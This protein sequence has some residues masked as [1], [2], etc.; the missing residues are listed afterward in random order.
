M[1]KS[2]VIAGICHELSKLD[3]DAKIIIFAPSKEILEQNAEKL[4]LYGFDDIKV[5]SASCGRKEVGQYTMAT[6]GSVKNHPELFKGT[7]YA[8]IDEMQDVKIDAGGMYLKFFEQVGITRY[9]GLTATPYKQRQ[10]YCKQGKFLEYTTSVSLVNRFPPIK[11]KYNP[12]FAWGKILYKIEMKDLQDMGYLCPIKYYTEMPQATLRLNSTGGDYAKADIEEFGIQSWNR[13]LTVVTRLVRAKNPKRVL[14]FAPSVKASQSVSQALIERGISADH[15]DGKTPKKERDE[16][17]ARF[18]SGETQVMCNCQCLTAGFD[19]PALDT[20]VYAMPTLSP[21]RWIQACYTDDM[22]I[23]TPSG[24]VP[25]QSVKKGDNVYAFDIETSRIE[26]VPVLETINRPLGVG[27][28]VYK[29]KTVCGGIDVSMTSTHDLVLKHHDGRKWKKEELS[30]ALRRKYSYRVPVAGYQEVDNPCELTKNECMFIGWWLSDGSYDKSNQRYVITQSMTNALYVDEIRTILTSLNIGFSESIVKHTGCLSKYNDNV[31]FRFSKKTT[32][33]NKIGVEKW[34]SW[35]NKEGTPELERLSREQL[36][37]VL[38]GY[39]HGNGINKGQRD[40]TARTKAATFG[41]NKVLAEK[42]Q[43]LLIRRGIKATITT[44]KGRPMKWG[45]R[46]IHQ[47]PQT[48]LRWC[49]R[50]YVTMNGSNIKDGS[51]SGKKPYTRARWEEQEYTGNVYCIRN[52][53]GTTIMRRNGKVIIAGNCGRCARIDPDNPDKVSE[54]YDLVGCCLTMGRPETF[55]IVKEDG[56][57]DMLIS[58][59]GRIDNVPLATFRIPL[60]KKEKLDEEYT[61]WKRD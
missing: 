6:I 42:L 9:I 57:K 36:L 29:Y 13:I 49:K 55:R 43:S 58:E 44:I 52:R 56:F 48:I 38:D 61:I 40:Y 35:L 50:D 21:S 24:F 39:Y 23:L 18:R 47:K 10:K 51:I 59:R 5:Y 60:Q 33:P 7:K 25:I 32:K 26:K 30:D 27:E 28:K 19:L 22:E 45:D 4:E 53:L 34:S 54:V 2:W 15:V 20:I 1:G 31:V 12:Q 46:C 11:G 37:W 16:K 3:P 14:V 8:I 41:T 17:I